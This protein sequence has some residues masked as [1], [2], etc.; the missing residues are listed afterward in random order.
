[1]TEDQKMMR[2][3]RG[4]GRWFRLD[5]DHAPTRKVALRLNRLGQIDLDQEHQRARY[6]E[7]NYEDIT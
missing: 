4:V 5:L 3:A 6:R 7:P 1:M 2:Y